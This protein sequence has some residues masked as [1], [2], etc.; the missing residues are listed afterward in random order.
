[1]IFVKL[2]ILIGVVYLIG[3]VITTIRFWLE[4][5]ST[6]SGNTISHRPVT[7]QEWHLD[8]PDPGDIKY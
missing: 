8:G 1:M 2:A 5:P 4:P 6:H 7:I 3:W